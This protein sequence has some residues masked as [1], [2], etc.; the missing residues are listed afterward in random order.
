MAGRT[1]LTGHC[2]P[3]WPVVVLAFASAMTTSIASQTLADA[4]SG[5]TNIQNIPVSYNIGYGAAI[6]GIFTDFSG[7][8]AG[9]VDCHFSPDMG[10]PSGHLDLTPGPSWANLVNAASFDDPTQTYVIPNH[11]EQS[12]LFRKVNCDDPGEKARMPLDNYFGGLT[13]EQQALI[14]D[15]IAEG[16]PVGNTNAIFRNGFDIRGFD[17]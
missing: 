13:P 14:Y 17:Q 3:R 6:Q 8:S 5:C 11:P 12:L 9:C 4:P 7:M 15:W 1:A 16:A 10:I 2:M